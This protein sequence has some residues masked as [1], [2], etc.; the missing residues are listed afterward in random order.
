MLGISPFL[1]LPM[2]SWRC[3][4]ILRMLRKSL[5][6]PIS[7]LHTFSVKQLHCVFTQKIALYYGCCYGC[8]YCPSFRYDSDNKISVDTLSKYLCRYSMTS[9]RQLSLLR[10]LLTCL[11]WYCNDEDRSFPSSSSFINSGRF[12]TFVLSV[13]FNS[14]FRSISKVLIS[15]YVSDSSQIDINLMPWNYYCY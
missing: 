7:V 15:G 13:I 6:T 3:L 1:R 5:L 12:S 11:K 2:N 14:A 10:M 9:S 4:G 8:C